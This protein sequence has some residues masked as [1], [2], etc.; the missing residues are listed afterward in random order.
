MKKLGN[1]MLTVQLA[2]AVCHR[3]WQRI[4]GQGCHQRVP[5][6]Q[7]TNKK[8]QSGPSFP[9]LVSLS[10][11]RNSQLLIFKDSHS[12]GRLHGP[13]Q[14]KPVSPWRQSGSILKLGLLL[15]NQH[16]VAGTSGFIRRV[17]VTW[18]KLML[19]GR[20]TGPDSNQPCCW[21]KD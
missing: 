8:G 16:F 3:L 13:D 10:V 14:G 18:S 17:V 9:S 6:I 1:G 15:G 5:Q 21:P 2:A 19:F 12:S 11:V 4:S 7:E 20:P